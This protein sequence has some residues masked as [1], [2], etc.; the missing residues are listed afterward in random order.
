MTNTHIHGK[1]RVTMVNLPVPI[2]TTS[3]RGLAF[4]AL[5]CPKN[6]VA[7]T[8]VLELAVAAIAMFLEVYWLV[9]LSLSDL[10]LDR[11]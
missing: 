3:L 11:E 9:F 7:L 4:E 5:V 8:T 10:V 6:G 1:K 2:E